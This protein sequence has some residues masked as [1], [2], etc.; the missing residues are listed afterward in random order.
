MEQAITITDVKTED[1]DILWEKVK[2]N[3]ELALE[4]AQGEYTMEDI[5]LALIEGKMHLWIG[6]D[7]DANLLASAVCELVKYPQKTVCYVVLAGG[8][9]FDLWS[10]ASVCIEDWAKDNGAHAIGA[11]TRKGLVKKFQAFGYSTAYTVVLKDLT[12][13]R[14]H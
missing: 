1:I 2:G 12:T 11:Y 10:E 6:Y 8:G 9:F 4:Y 3:L 14:L 13:R 5:H 7:E